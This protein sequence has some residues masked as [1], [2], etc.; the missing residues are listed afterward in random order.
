MGDEPRSS[1][2]RSD[3]AF[4]A[5]PCSAAGAEALG[6]SRQRVQQLASDP[7]F[8]APTA[9]LKGGSI[10]EREAV[11]AWAERTGRAVDR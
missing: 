7:D 6:V 4:S 5:Q 8:P 1:N 11:Q 10:W 9:V 3:C 2:R